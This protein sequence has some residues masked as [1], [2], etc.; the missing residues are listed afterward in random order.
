M[1]FRRVVKGTY[2]AFLYGLAPGTY[3]LNVVARNA[4]DVV[5]QRRIEGTVDEDEEWV[6][7]IDIEEE[8]GALSVAPSA[9]HSSLSSTL[10][11]CC[12]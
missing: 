7:P 6:V 2:Q 5:C 3:H 9:T 12:C 11:L 10:R 1:T 8:E 4:G